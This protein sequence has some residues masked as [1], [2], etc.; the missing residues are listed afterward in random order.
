[1]STAERLARLDP[2]SVAKCI[3]DENKSFSITEEQLFGEIQKYA[4][5]NRLPGES[6]AQAF[7]RVFSADNDEGLAFRKAVAVCKGATLEPLMVGGAAAQ[8]VNDP[9]DALAQLNRLAEE[10][11]RR[12]PELTLAQ[13]F[14]RVYSERPDLASAERRQAVAKFSTRA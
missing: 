9:K 6:A 14:A 12:S 5:A 1:M 11:R 4:S 3:V 7:S 13:S 8:D 2:V 10:Q